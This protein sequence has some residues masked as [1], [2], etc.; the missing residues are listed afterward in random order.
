M[1]HHML[2][3]LL[4]ATLTQKEL[5][6]RTCSCDVPTLLLTC[7]L[8][9]SAY[10][11][12]QRPPPQPIPSASLAWNCVNILCCISWKFANCCSK[13]PK[14]SCRLTVCRWLESSFL[15]GRRWLCSPDEGSPI[16]GCFSRLHSAR[17]TEISER[18]FLEVTSRPEPGSTGYFARKFSVA[19]PMPSSWQWGFTETVGFWP[20]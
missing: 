4:R 19:K 14:Y 15:W 20:F 2:H 9:P 18:A 8:S 7:S 12:T 5:S 1:F 17:S 16:Q 3:R 11:A 10:F 13:S 6:S